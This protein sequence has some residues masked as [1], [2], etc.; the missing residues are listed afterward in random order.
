MFAQVTCYN[1]LGLVAANLDFFGYRF[2]LVARDRKDIP[3]GVKPTVVP[4][5][6]YPGSTELEKESPTSIAQGS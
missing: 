2:I 3:S 6:G 5:E 4:T 1:A